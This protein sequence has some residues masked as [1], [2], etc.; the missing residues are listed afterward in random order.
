MSTTE[1]LHE[2]ALAAI[3]DRLAGLK[4]PTRLL[5]SH[6]D[7][8]P[9]DIRAITGKGFGCFAINDIKRG[10]RILEESP[11]LSTPIGFYFHEDIKAEFDKLSPTDQAL[12]F[13][14]HSAHGQN[15]ASW[16]GHVHP[17]V[18]EKGKKRILE[19]HNARIGKKPSIVS[20]FQ[21]N[22]MEKESGAAVYVHASRFNHACNP[23]AGFQWN[24]AIKKETIHAVRDIRAGEEI[25]LSYC[26]ATQNKAARLYQLKHYGFVCDCPACAD[27]DDPDSFA[28]KSAA[29]RYRLSEL[30]RE[31]EP[32]RGWAL[33]KAGTKDG[34]AQYLLEYIGL[35]IEE[36]DYSGRLS[37]AYLDLGLFCESKGD[38]KMAQQATKKALKIRLDNMGSDYPD[39]KDYAT[40]VKRINLAI[41]E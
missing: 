15:P 26:D 41:D 2:D 35:L 5:T 4:L 31:L 19:Q 39:I 23:N 8:A 18:A 13:S 11:L 24:P 37:S 14:L 10:T 33:H 32:V 25:T 17:M 7:G 34:F 1:T 20:I 6:A 16:P 21:T 30:Q 38:L 9:Y 40:V 27:D 12:Y 28:A 36:G 29:R 3:N 22:C